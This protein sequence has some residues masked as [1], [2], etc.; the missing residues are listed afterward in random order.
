MIINIRDVP[1][2]KYV[3]TMMFLTETGSN[4]EKYMS[5]YHPEIRIG[6]A[7]LYSNVFIKMLGLLGSSEGKSFIEIGCG[8]AYFLHALKKMGAEVYG[9]DMNENGGNQQK[10]GVNFALK[11]ILEFPDDAVLSPQDLFPQSRV[12]KFDALLTRDFLEKYLYFG[13]QGFSEE[14]VEKMLKMTRNLSDLQIHETGL[15]TSLLRGIDVGK[16]GYDVL[17]FEETYHPNCD[18]HVLKVKT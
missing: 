7:M 6:S 5:D 2:S 3:N 15:N 1:E 8:P 10:Y 13:M 17:D 12:K 9:L 11:N 16:L 18:L 14:D 4:Y